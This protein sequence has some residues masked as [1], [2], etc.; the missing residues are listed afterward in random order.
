MSAILSEK[1]RKEATYIAGMKAYVYGYPMVVMD[2]TCDVITAV[3]AP[4]PQ[5]R[6]APINQF[7]NTPQYVTPDM[8]NVVR[9]SRDTLWTTAWLDLDTEPIVLSLPD[10]HDRYHV[11]S[12]MN[13]WT[14]VFGSVGKRTHGTRPC[15]FLITGPNWKGSAPADIKETFRSSTRYAWIAG[16]TQANG[17]EDFAAV[18][19][20]Q[21]Q[22]KL[23][24]L[25]AWGQ[26]Y[27]PP[28]SV[29][30][31]PSVNRKVPPPNQVAAMDAGTFFNRLAMAMKDNPP[32]AADAEALA[33]LASIGV[34][35]GQPFDITTVDPD[36]AKVL[37]RAVKDI[38]VKMNQGGSNRES[39]NGWIRV[40]NLGRYGTDYVTRAG[41]A[42]GGLGANQQEDTIYPM[43]LVDGDGNVLDSAHKY[44]MHYERDQFPPTNATWSF[45]LYQGPHYVP[46]PINRY[47]IAPW[48]PLKYNPDGSL[49]IYI[50]ATSPGPDKEANWLP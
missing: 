34:E 25:S 15:D 22:Y 2:V 47:H 16:Q 21:A 10:T 38:Q 26:P 35:P 49:D 32:Y 5:G 3:P 37:E 8:K 17:E 13:M 50:Q 36:V 44:V 43:A 9:I 20:L 45:S 19:A 18:N 33:A 28:E 30:V 12:M 14:D 24:P 46:N 40:P 7:A 29:P 41:I 48:M 11:F 1:T 31:D 6:G 42:K 27:T 4:H 23:T 39:L